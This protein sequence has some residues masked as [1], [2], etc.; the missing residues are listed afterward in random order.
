M[1]ERFGYALA[2]GR[3]PQSAIEVDLIASLSEGV[4]SL[5]D[6]APSMVIK[7]FDA[8]EAKDS[9]LVAAVECITHVADG[10]PVLLALAVTRRG[11]EWYIT[12]EGIDRVL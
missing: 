2:Y 7:Y 9:G 12:L 8:D 6:I 4:G 1:A 5:G 11:I 3:E 10:S